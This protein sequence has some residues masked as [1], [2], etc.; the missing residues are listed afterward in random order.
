MSSNIKVALSVGSNVGDREE[1]LRNAVKLLE[2]ELGIKLKKSPV[3]ESPPMY[4]RQQRDFYN[5][6]LS[7]DTELSIDE[8]YKIIKS[9]ESKMGRKKTADKGPRVI[10]IDIVFFGDEVIAG[11]E[12]TVPHMDMH[13]RLFVLKPLS[14]IMGDFEH[15]TMQDTVSELL[16]NCMD[17]SELKKIKG[18]W[19]NK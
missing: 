16:E 12:L 13:N 5:C 19:K 1:N 11:E 10:D 14:Y 4:Y 3:F 6:C 15:P 9:V 8:L 18:F 7:F 2:K 17:G